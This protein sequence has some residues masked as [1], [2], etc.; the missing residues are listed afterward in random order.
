MAVELYGTI[1]FAFGAG[2]VTFFAPCSYA[3]LP[4]YVGYY[5]A[6]T[7][8]QSPP[9]A[10][11][12]ARGIAAAGG[13]LATFAVLSAVAVVASDVVERA[14]PAVEWLVGL[15][16][17]GFGLVIVTGRTGSL[18]VS[19]PQRRATV[20]GFGLFGAVYALAAL[21]CV[22]PM[23]LA[24]TV[25]SLTFSAVGTAAVLA[26]YAGGFGVLM[27]VATV[28]IA[29]GHDAVT[30]RLADRTDTLTRL[31]GAILIVAGVGQLYIAAT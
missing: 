30:T 14:L 11:V 15:L 3:L 26:A 10:G 13:V 7:E 19:L 21:A 22:L 28:A 29:V 27:V 25:Q 8:D 12:F 18:H 16:L 24:V 23:F 1:A 5:V 2:I 31:A 6:A 20:F 9:M 17:V 4:G